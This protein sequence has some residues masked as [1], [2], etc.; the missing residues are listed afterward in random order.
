MDMDEEQIG[1]EQYEEFALFLRRA[2]S[3]ALRVAAEDGRLVI[4]GEPGAGKTVEML[5]LYQT[6]RE[7]GRDVLLLQSQDLAADNLGALR[8]ALGLSHDLSAVLRTWPGLEAGFLLVDALD[9]ARADPSGRILRD[10][11]RL[12]IDLAPRWHLVVSIRKYDLWYGQD[13]QK[14]FRGQPVAEHLRD[15]F[16]PRVRHLRIP[17]FD[18]EELAYVVEQSPTLRDLLRQAGPVLRPPRPRPLLPPRPPGP[19]SPPRL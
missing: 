4:A 1:D 13:W 15:P 10:L 14:L 2:V 8:L 9:A 11:A 19:P 16:C 18:D 6:L 17:L 12:V 7:Q 3:E 5:G